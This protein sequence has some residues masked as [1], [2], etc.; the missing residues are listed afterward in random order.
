[1]TSAPRPSLAAPEAEML[2][3][4]PPPRVISWTAGLLITMFVVA[5]LGAF[6]VHVPETVRCQFVLVPENGADP[7][8]SPVVAVVHSLKAAEGQE[9][10]Q[11]AELFVLRSDQIRGWQTQLQIL[12]E[13]LASFQ[14]RE[15][16][17]EEYY[18]AQ[19]AIKEEEL[20]Q[21]EREVG[22]RE[23]HL[24]TIRDFLARN[25]KLAAEKLVSEVEILHHQLD[26]AESEK[27]LNVAQRTV[28]QVSLQ[29]Q[30]L[31][32]ER[33]RQRSEEESE[34]EKVKVRIAA[35][36]RQVENCSGDLMFIRAPY[37]GMVISLSHR[38]V[39]GVVHNGD[40]LCQ[41]ARIEGEARARLLVREQ[42]LP[43]L[44]P[45]QKVRLFFEAFP[46]QRYGTATG[47]LEWISSA[48]VSSSEG[49]TFIARAVLDQKNFSSPGHVHP[50]RVGMK[51][52][53][54]IVVGRRTLIEYAFEPIRQLRE[55]IQH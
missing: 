43:R 12:Q 8:Q 7:I 37:H 22:F 48:A 55:Q 51:G 5:A 20:K 1:M 15:T 24:S 17:S 23:K 25:E 33:S 47:N 52:E 3:E 32:S 41:V 13:D 14:K 36:Q 26:V 44:A 9:V 46:Y 31:Q 49:S 19:I 28:Q 45:G 53:A 10:Q 40:E 38:N 11:G 39:G 42:G 29:R 2:P 50:L 4:R 34:I 18:K 16:R 30:Q 21:V 27:D 54:R 35:L 6:L